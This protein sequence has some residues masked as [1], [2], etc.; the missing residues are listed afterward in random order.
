[1]EF[2]VRNFLCLVFDVWLLDGAPVERTVKEVE[3]AELERNADM[4]HVKLE[5]DD[6]ELGLWVGPVGVAQ[7]MLL[8]NGIICLLLGS[9]MLSLCLDP[10]GFKD[11][12]LHLVDVEWIVLLNCDFVLAEIVKELLKEWIVRVLQ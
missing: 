4:P 12:I 2:F 9:L 8:F 7:L 3:R 6:W 10:D 5:W 11:E 1:M